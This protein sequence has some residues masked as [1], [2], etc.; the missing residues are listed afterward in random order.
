[1]VVGCGSKAM[2]PSRVFGTSPDLGC[3]VVP[4][5]VCR[6]SSPVDPSWCTEEW[7]VPDVAVGVGSSELADGGGADTEVSI[8]VD[9]G[10][11]VEGPPEGCNVSDLLSLSDS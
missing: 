2:K 4:G 10:V 11:P 6:I 8:G 1:M 3:S 9:A 7:S 5:S